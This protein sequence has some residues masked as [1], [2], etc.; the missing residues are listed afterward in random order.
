[1]ERRLP[2]GPANAQTH[3]GLPQL[4]LEG[5]DGA[6]LLLDLCAA[7]LQLRLQQ[8]GGL[9]VVGH[10]AAGFELS[11]LQLTDLHAQSLTSRNTGVVI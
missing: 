1:M 3:L 6:V 8:L 11:L 5:P 4:G 2:R 9:F 7:V 10:P